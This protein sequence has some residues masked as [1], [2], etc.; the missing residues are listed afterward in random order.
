MRKSPVI[1]A[2]ACAFSLAAA[3]PAAATGEVGPLNYGH[4][5][6]H[7]Q[8]DPQTDYVGPRTELEGRINQPR[9]DEPPGQH[10]EYFWGCAQDH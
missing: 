2:V 7:G 8:I 4:C 9:A 3:Q 10:W 6:A 1:G 5:V